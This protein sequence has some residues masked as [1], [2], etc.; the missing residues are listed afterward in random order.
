MKFEVVESAGEWIVRRE[1]EEIARFA[2]QDE[3]LSHVAD[4]LREADP[5]EGAS[6]AMR[7]QRRA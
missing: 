4:R 2:G 7:Y 1:G 3:A 6:L 5:A